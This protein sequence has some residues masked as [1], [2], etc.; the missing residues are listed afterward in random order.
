[1]IVETLKNDLNGREWRNRNNEK[2][3]DTLREI[4]RNMG[5][6]HEF[7]FKCLVKLYC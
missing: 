6:R 2:Q 5:N 7:N 1:M 4:H 3:L